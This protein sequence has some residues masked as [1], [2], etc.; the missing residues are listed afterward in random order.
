M[1]D[2]EI[3][4]LGRSAETVLNSEAFSKALDEI[5]THKIR[6][7]ADGIYKTPQEREEAYALIRGAKE[8]RSALNMMLD[9]MKISRDKV[10]R[11]R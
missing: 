11:N 9:R 8:F 4:R 7:W 3:I 1:N 10:E 5:E 2:D 6:M